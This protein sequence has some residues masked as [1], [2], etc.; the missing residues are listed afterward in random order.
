MSYW[1]AKYTDGSTLLIRERSERAAWSAARWHS[2]GRDVKDVRFV[3]KE[4]LR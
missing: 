2:K 1:Y 4:W 3:R